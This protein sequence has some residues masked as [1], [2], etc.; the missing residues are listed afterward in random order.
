MTN[1]QIPMTNEEKHRTPCL[2]IGAWS[3]V[4]FLL[5][6]LFFR[7]RQPLQNLI[8]DAILLRLIGAQ[9][10]VPVGIFGD[11]VERLAGVFGQDLV[12]HLAITQNLV[13]L[14]FNVADLALHPAIWLMQ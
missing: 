14:N 12:Q 13:G 5:V 7:S 1:D 6:F 10:E 11:L 2:V 4:L 8:Y 3:L 9:E